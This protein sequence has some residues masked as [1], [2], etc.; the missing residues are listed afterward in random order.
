MPS[1]A[2]PV[3]SNFDDDTDLNFATDLLWIA[4]SIVSTTKLVQDKARYEPQDG[5]LL[6]RQVGITDGRPVGSRDGLR[7]G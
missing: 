2:I 6:G 1:K 3:G 5:R 7:K 4:V